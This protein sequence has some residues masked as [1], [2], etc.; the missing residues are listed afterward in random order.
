MSSEDSFPDPVRSQ[1]FTVD[2]L[3]GAFDMLVLFILLC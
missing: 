1:L 3:D 2:E